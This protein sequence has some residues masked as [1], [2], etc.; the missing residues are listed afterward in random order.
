MVRIFGRMVVGML[1]LMPKFVVGKFSKRYVAGATLDDAVKV[2]KKLSAENAC[3]TVDVL[4]EEIASLD[5]AQF[6]IDEYD[7]VLEAIIENGLDANISIKPTAFGLLIDEAIAYQ[8][9]EKLLKKAAESDIFV[10]LD[11]EDYRVTQATID[12]VLKMHEKGL[13]NVGVVIQ[14]RMFRT[15]EDIAGLVKTLGGATDI[16]ICKGIYLESEDIAYTKYQDIV[17]ALNNSV[18]QL[19][20]LGAYTA[21]ASHDLPVIDYSLAALNSRGLG[22]GIADPRD[23]AGGPRPHKGLGYEFQ[24]LLGVRGNVRRKLAKEG[25][26]TRVYIPYGRRWYEYGM[27]R[28]RENPDIAWHVTKSVIMPWTNRK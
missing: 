11:M 13:S 20:D 27:R 24:M 18:D 12:I 7:R 14:A 22:P 6:F 19:L 26:L 28:L 3:F 10:R 21:I 23:N 25:H 2:M 16:R 8:N 4:G 5:E 17:D 1:P 15:K 9:I